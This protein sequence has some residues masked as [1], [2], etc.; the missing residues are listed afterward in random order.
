MVTCKGNGKCYS[1]NELTC[2]Y[3]KNNSVTCKHNC[4][5]KKCPNYL[6][7]G[8][9]IPYYIYKKNNKMCTY[10]HNMFSKN[11]C[12]GRLKFFDN[13]ECP[14]CLDETKCVSLPNCNHYICI[15]CFKRCFYGDYS[16]NS[17][18]KFPYSADYEKEY[19]E[20]YNDPIWANDDKVK[21]WLKKWNE[22][23][24]GKRAKFLNED[25]LQLCP[26][27]RK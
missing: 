16:D 6:V 24:E 14:I 3:T 27:C 2:Y 9:I 10:C 5:I 18:P 1:F 21:E 20:Y 23:S 7:C 17:E 12:K 25:Y 4:K 15:D 26:I 11:S 19:Y 22:W 13:K 8:S